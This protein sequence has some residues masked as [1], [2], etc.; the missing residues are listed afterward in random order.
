VRL[1]D[2]SWDLDRTSLSLLFLGLLLADFLDGLAL[3]LL[4]DML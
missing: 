4:L 1:A 2:I 3:L